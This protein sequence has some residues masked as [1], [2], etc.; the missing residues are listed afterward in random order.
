VTQLAISFDEGARRRDVGHQSALSH[1]FTTSIRLA[2]Q[3]AAR[4]R[5]TFTSEDLLLTD[6]TAAALRAFPNALGACFRV[7]AKAGTIRPTG[8]YQAATRP[9]AR[10]RKIALWTGR[11]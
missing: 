9:E 11:P 4:T 3:H 8:Q 2:I 6:A 5:E 1:G 7:E 10:K